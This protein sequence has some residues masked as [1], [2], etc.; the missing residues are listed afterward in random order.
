MDKL[1]LNI[2][3]LLINWGLMKGEF[4]DQ[5]IKTTKFGLINNWFC[6]LITLFNLIR[7]TFYLFHP[8][9]SLIIRQLGDFGWLIGPKLMLDVI[10]INIKINLLVLMLLFRF[11]NKLF[12]LDFMKYDYDKQSFIKMNLDNNGSQRFTERFAIIMSIVKMFSYFCVSFYI[13]INFLSLYLF[14]N[15]YYLNYI[16]SLIIHYVNAWYIIFHLFG[17]L[18][19]IFQVKLINYDKLYQTLTNIFDFSDFLLLS[20]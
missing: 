19:I 2:N 6:F 15:D 14:E 3:S 5:T 18:A 13:F 7:F 12:W 20:Y 10:I 16:I 8:K 1:N 11:T 17:L 9:T 4:H